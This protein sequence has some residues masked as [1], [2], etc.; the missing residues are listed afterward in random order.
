MGERSETARRPASARGRGVLARAADGQAAPILVFMEL[1]LNRRLPW[2]VRV[3]MEAPARSFGG[4]G[5]R[6]LPRRRPRELFQRQRGSA[7]RGGR[8][9]CNGQGSLRRG[10]WADAN[11]RSFAAAADES[12]HGASGGGRGCEARRVTGEHEQARRHNASWRSRGDASGAVVSRRGGATRAG[13][14]WR[15]RER[16]VRW[17]VRWRER[18]AGLSW[19]RRP[20]GAHGT[21]EL[22][23]DGEGAV[24]EAH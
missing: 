8:R 6:E 4:G 15:T 5:A 13:R 24:Q 20:D 21:A 3:P 12:T 7:Q 1:G 10:A 17:L 14:S 23:V 11:R 9:A 19:R 2:R 18:A 22:A 16:G